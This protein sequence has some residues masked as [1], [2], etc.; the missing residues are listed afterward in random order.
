MTTFTPALTDRDRLVLLVAEHAE[1]VHL[2]HVL[3]R[4]AITAV[5]P[6]TARGVA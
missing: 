2:R 4:P 6:S 5:G 3:A 1:L